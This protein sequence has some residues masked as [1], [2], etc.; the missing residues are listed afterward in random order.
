MMHGVTDNA[1]QEFLA[2]VNSSVLLTATAAGVVAL[3]LGFI[4]FR[5]IVAPLNGLAAASDKIATGNLTARGSVR[6]DDEIALVA[7]SFNAMADNPTRSET[8][9]R[10]MLADIVH[11]LRN[12]YRSDRH[13]SRQLLGC[14]R[15]GVISSALGWGRKNWFKVYFVESLPA[16]VLTMLTLNPVNFALNLMVLQIVCSWDLL[17]PS[18]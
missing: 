11:E 17:F 2:R 6:G 9:R 14:D 18:D 12:P 16:L 13:F 1:A 5:K 3:A 7:R 15:I 8:A 10:N 4:L